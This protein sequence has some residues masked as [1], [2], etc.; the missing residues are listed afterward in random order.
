MS[1]NN[2]FPEE[3]K[4]LDLLAQEEDILG[5]YDLHVLAKKHKQDPPR[6]EIILKK[7][8]ATRTH[9]SLSGI[10]SKEPLDKILKIFKKQE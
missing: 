3:Q 10:K 2:Q 5:F 7:L 1:K 4:F 6:M 9:F 8:K